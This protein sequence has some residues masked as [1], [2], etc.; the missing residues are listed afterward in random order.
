MR[1]SRRTRTLRIPTVD[2]AVSGRPARFASF[3]L[4]GLTT[5]IVRGDFPPGTV[6]PTEPA[7]CKEF[8]FS[9]TVVREALK[10]LEERSL[11]RI[12]QGRG[13]TVQPRESWSAWTERRHRRFT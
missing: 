4:D 9:L 11:V 13:T 10:L 5:R 6:L 12:E 8:G 7:L 1:R 2:G 3:V